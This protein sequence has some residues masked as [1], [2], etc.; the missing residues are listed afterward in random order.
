MVQSQEN[1]MP[2]V[3]FSVKAILQLT[4]KMTRHTI[5]RAHMQ[6]LVVA[7]RFGLLRAHLS[8]FSRP[9]SRVV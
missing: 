6:F 7:H 1:L 5:R 9:I 3:M 8:F 4:D 2:F